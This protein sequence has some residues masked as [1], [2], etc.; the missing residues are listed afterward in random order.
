MKKKITTRGKRQG[1]SSLVELTLCFLV[2]VTMIFGTLEFA[3]AVFAYNSVAYLAQDAARW[4][5]VNGSLS[6]SPATSTDVSN[7]VKSEAVGLD[8]S[9][10]NVST[11]WPSGNT[12]GSIVQVTVNYTANPLVGLTLQ[13]MTFSASSQFYINH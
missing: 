13:A 8:T 10:V 11:T 3:W 2:F 5:S 9:L 7:H 6:T 4:A 12:P 1:G